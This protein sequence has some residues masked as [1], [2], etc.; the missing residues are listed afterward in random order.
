MS[1]ALL[2]AGTASEVGKSAI[3]AGLC[4]LLYRKG[5]KVAPFKAQNMALNSVV[6]PDGGEIGRAQAA[7]AHAAGLQPETAMNPILLKPTDEGRSQV[8][9]MGKPYGYTDARSFRSLKKSLLSVVLD[10]FEDLRSRFDVV[11]CEGAGSPAEINLRESDLANMELARRAGIPV[12][13]VGDIDRGGV[14]ASFYGTLALLA[15]ADQALVSGFIVNK[16]R[17]DADRS[18]H[19]AASAGRARARGG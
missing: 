5:I 16:F 15:P 10:A 19:G 1:G 2:V 9:V 6:T 12:V 4:R 7:Q 3:V 14:L 17:G 13:V 8:I 11:V 18:A